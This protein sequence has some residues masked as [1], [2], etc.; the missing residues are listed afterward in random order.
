MTPAVETCFVVTVTVYFR[1]DIRPVM[2][3]NVVVPVC[4]GDPLVDGDQL[5]V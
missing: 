3:I 5:T 4:I 1:P 2:S